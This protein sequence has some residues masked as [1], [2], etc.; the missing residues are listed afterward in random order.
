ME[1]DDIGALYAIACIWP[2]S[3]SCQAVTFIQ[4]Q[5]ALRSAVPS[6]V[7]VKC[8]FKD[9]LRTLKVFEMSDVLQ[10]SF[11]AELGH[12]GRYQKTDLVD[13]ELCMIWLRLKPHFKTHSLVI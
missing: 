4:S 9:K 13:R 5:R 6:A 3:N 12:P 2:H 10:L 11:R 8:R 7:S 1:F